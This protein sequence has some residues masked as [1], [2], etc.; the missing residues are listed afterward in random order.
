[1]FIPS[2]F[3]SVNQY[4]ITGAGV[5]NG[6][7]DITISSVNV[8]NTIIFGS[9]ASSDLSGFPDGIGSGYFSLLN[10]T[11]VRFFTYN[12]GSDI[13][14]T[15]IEFYSGF[16]RQPVQYNNIVI[17]AGTAGNRA[18]T[19]VG[20][21]AFVIPLCMAQ[22]TGAAQADMGSVTFTVT[23]TSNVLVSALRYGAGGAAGFP[24]SALIG[25]CVV[26]PR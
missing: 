7:N 4:A 5:V 23:L 16:M 19:A 10:A 17:S 14:F 26:D 24:D 21:K 12:G 22:N 8:N 15:V 13:S 25:F 2:L 1:M 20:S 6:N 18:I 3:K 9:F 11:T